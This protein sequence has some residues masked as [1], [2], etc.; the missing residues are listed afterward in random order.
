MRE[1]FFKTEDLKKKC[2]KRDLVWFCSKLVFID[3][4]GEA[5]SFFFLSFMPEEQSNNM[6]F[7]CQID[8][9]CIKEEENSVKF[10]QTLITR[11][12]CVDAALLG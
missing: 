8:W 1:W 5:S 2:Y 11:C 7:C 3:A 10:Y 6:F 9:R 12:E 4:A